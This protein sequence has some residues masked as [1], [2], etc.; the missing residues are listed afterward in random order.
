MP[1]FIRPATYDSV[2]TV[3]GRLLD[4]AGLDARGKSVFVK[5][6]IL[7][8]FAP[9]RGVTTHPA[10]VRA[11]VEALRRRGAA[12]IIVGDNPGMRGYAANERC[13]RRSGILEAA[14]GAWRNIGLEPIEVPVTS[15][16]APRFV[17][18]HVVREADLF[19]SLPKFKTHVATVITGAVKN[20]Y[21]LLVGAQKALLHRVARGPRDF[22][23][24]VVDVY[25]VRPPD[26]VLMDG[27]VAMQG[28]GPSSHDL[29]DVNLLLAGT[30]GVEVDAVMAA[31]M[32][33]DPAAIP[34]LA[35]AHRRGLGEIDLARIDL[36]GDLVPVPVFRVPFIGV[37]AGGRPRGRLGALLRRLHAENLGTFLA[38][39]LTYV[40]VGRPTLRRRACARCG[41]CARQCPVDA[42]TLAP[43]PR[44]D[45]RTCV[46][47]YCCNEFCEYDAMTVQRRVRL[48]RRRP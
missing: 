43:Y 26:F 47:C 36:R 21:G 7:G 42:I 19:I 10:V 20:S 35:E 44:I 33:A 8:D 16:F 18:S 2:A 5:P 38:R 48:F 46:L 1:V 45:R 13:A 6:N 31:V 24:A 32:G 25:A 3:I 22:A 9:E 30:N 4:E 34:L 40:A 11:V 37:Q 41:V 28:N 39:L 15:R 27:I 23:E 17:V 14:D 29:R 12:N